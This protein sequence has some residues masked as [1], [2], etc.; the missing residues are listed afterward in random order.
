MTRLVWDRVGDRVF[1]TGVNRGVLY[2]RGQDGVAWNGL[3]ALNESPT[4]GEAKP[5]YV[6]GY[7]YANKASRE[8]FEGTIEAFTYPPEFDQCEGTAGLGRGLYVGSQRRRPFSLS[9]RTLIGNDTKG[10]NYGYKIHLVYNALVS[11]VN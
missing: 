11:P 4:G 9:Y 7:K 2:P 5:F 1:Q 3:T 6:D 10:L 8:E